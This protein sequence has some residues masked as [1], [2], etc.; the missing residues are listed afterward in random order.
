MFGMME[1]IFSFIRRQV[2]LRTDTADA[3]G[4]LHAKLAEARASIKADTAATR[5]AIGTA[6][7]LK[8]SDNVKHTLSTT[9][10]FLSNDRH[11]IIGKFISPY[12]GFIK[13]S[14]TARRNSSNAESIKFAAYQAS[15][16]TAGGSSRY[17]TATLPGDYSE[18]VL[19]PIGSE[20]GV[21]TDYCVSIEKYSSVRNAAITL[22]PIR[23]WAGEPIIFTLY[24]YE[25]YF[26]YKDLKISYDVLSSF[27]VEG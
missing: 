1:G 4:S 5:D 21:S 6:R 3:G 25:G 15:R 27:V 20:G 17:N 10:K 16:N 26:Y 14:I 13:A 9:E 18:S 19:I 22:P 11:T 8:Y 2:G 24:S 12:S 23:V 7:Y